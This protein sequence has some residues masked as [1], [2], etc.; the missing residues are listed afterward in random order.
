MCYIFDSTLPPVCPVTPGSGG[1]AWR[2]AGKPGPPHNPTALRQ[3]RQGRCGPA[4]ARNRLRLPVGAS[5]EETRRSAALQIDVHTGLHRWSRAPLQS[6]RH[7]LWPRLS[8]GPALAAYRLRCWG[9]RPS[10]AQSRSL[11]IG[12]ETAHGLFAVCVDSL[13]TD[14]EDCEL[15][16]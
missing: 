2:A 11:Y 6:R 16:A 9:A 5:A 13:R 3:A 1:C 12:F 4:G 8:V 14:C 15:S 10:A 7:H